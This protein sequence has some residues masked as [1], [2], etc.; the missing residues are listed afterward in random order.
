MLDDNF[1]PDPDQWRGLS[2]PAT[3]LSLLL[4][5]YELLNWTEDIQFTKG[6]RRQFIDYWH[7]FFDDFVF[8]DN[9][10]CMVGQ[11]LFEDELPYVARFIEAFEPFAGAVPDELLFGPV[12]KSRIKLPP[13]V[14]QAAKELYGKL[15]E[16]G[17]PDVAQFRK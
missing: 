14:I 16:R 7:F 5:L 4:E 3:R 12:D 9:P 15:L 17:D 10:Q 6:Y 2:I 13:I 11:S 8:K 1:P